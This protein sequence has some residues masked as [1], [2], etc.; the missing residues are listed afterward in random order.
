MQLICHSSYYDKDK[1][2]NLIHSPKK[3]SSILCSNINGIGAKFDELKIFVEEI[4]EKYNFEF[5]A[6]CLQECQFK[7]TDKT[8]LSKYKLD[9][10]N[11]LP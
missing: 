3:C 6:I 4:H 9:N 8:I 5:S 7:E 11:I 1:F 10:Y 2:G